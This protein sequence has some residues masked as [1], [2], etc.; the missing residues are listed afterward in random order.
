MAQRKATI[1]Y[2]YLSTA[3]AAT[4]NGMMITL[5]SIIIFIQTFNDFIH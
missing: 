5:P 1:M 2:C 4:I 3:A